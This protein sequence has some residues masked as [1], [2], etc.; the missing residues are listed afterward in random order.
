MLRWLL[1]TPFV[2]WLVLMLLAVSILLHSRFQADMS[3]FMPRHPTASQAVLVNQLQEGVA[4]KVVLI[5]IDG[6]TSDQLEATSVAFAEALRGSAHFGFVTNGRIE[7]DAATQQLLFDYR[8]LLSDAVRAERFSVDGLKQSLALRASELAGS[9]GLLTAQFI[10]SDPTGETLHIA[11]GLGSGYATAGSSDSA[12]GIWRNAAGT[13]ALLIAAARAP[14]TDLDA[15]ELALGDLRARWNVLVGRPPAAT[16]LLA[17]GPLFAVQSRAAIRDDSSRLALI[18]TCLIALLLGWFYRSPRL[19]LLGLLPVL[20]GIV[21]GLAAVGLGFSMIHGMTVGFGITLI[22][23]AVDYA[24][25]L[26][27]QRPADAPGEPH[28]SSASRNLWRTIGI[29]VATSVA[30]F[31]TLLL[32]DF[33]GL[34]QLGLFTIVGLLAAAAVTRWVLPPLMPKSTRPRETPR[35]AAVLQRTVMAL[36]RTRWW[37]VGAVLTL[38]C[39]ALFTARGPFLSH[40]LL[41][42]SPIPQS[43]QKLDAALRADL[44]MAETGQ[45]IALSGRSEAALLESCEQVLTA[46]LPLV[47]SAIIQDVDAPCKYLPSVRT[48]AARQASLPSRG[49]LVSALA[50]ATIGSP[51]NPAAF[52]PFIDAVNASRVLPPLTSA[53][54]AATALGTGYAS[55]MHNGKRADDWRAMITLRGLQPGAAD[56]K[57]SV[58][59]ISAALKPFTKDTSADVLLLNV[60]AESDALYSGYLRETLRWSGVGLLCIAVLLSVA[61]H[62]PLRAVKVMWPLALSGVTTASALIL[63]GTALNLLHLVGLL[64]IVAVGSNYALFFSSTTDRADARKA[65][66]PTLLV[67][68]F[69]A[70]TTTL[71]GFGL[72]AFSSVPVLNALGSTVG[73]GAFLALVFSAAFSARDAS[74]E[75]A[76]DRLG[77]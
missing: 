6:L 8:Y 46:L 17:G 21:M 23:E 2:W 26:F 74:A 12:S 47:E 33:Q 69:I 5:G 37:L 60:K 25:Y 58:D 65:N 15:L 18:G 39:A 38:G 4:S 22:G 49:A 36:Q 24:I 35:L 51:F 73:L 76:L 64:L 9:A 1:K 77:V 45:L 43:L 57:R 31:A 61:L 54:L 13:R 32:S 40:H 59:A 72:L 66:S 62:S 14:G 70:N 53:Q 27:I 48:Q 63:F 52:T 41:A 44:P 34:A 20:S 29:G 16:L 42:I 28:A 11:N 30:G 19:L 50:E 67:S 75:L 3:V 68:L 10:A 55:L 56:G 7:N 71:L